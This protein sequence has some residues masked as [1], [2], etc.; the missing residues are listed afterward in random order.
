MQPLL[1]RLFLLEIRNL[2][3]RFAAT[4]LLHKRL[5]SYAHLVTEAKHKVRRARE[6]AHGGYLF[7]G[8]IRVLQ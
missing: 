4:E 6:S 3:I 7:D 2:R 8:M 1:P 5:G